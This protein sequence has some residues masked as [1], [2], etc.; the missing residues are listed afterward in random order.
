[1]G[2]RREAL[3]WGCLSVVLAGIVVGRV[4]ADDRFILPA[5]ILAPAHSATVQPATSC[6]I[7]KAH[8]R[9]GPFAWTGSTFLYLGDWAVQST[10]V[11]ATCLVLAAQEKTL[12][13]GQGG[14]PVSRAEI[15]VHVFNT[16]APE[17]CCPGTDGAEK[18]AEWQAV[19]FDSARLGY[20]AGFTP[21]DKRNFIREFGHPGNFQPCWHSR[22]KDQALPPKPRSLPKW[23]ASPRTC[24]EAQACRGYLTAFS[25]GV[26]TQ[27]ILDRD[28]N[29]EM[30]ALPALAGAASLAAALVWMPP[31]RAGRRASRR[32][33]D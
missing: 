20:L 5:L 17:C 3:G 6:W 4:P 25:A 7:P 32:L 22:N 10:F 18:C 11:A 21:T 16:A 28:W 31:R 29:L 9:V 33:Q 19:A 27:V 1:M 23:R 12:P 15:T 30:L 24:R 2:Q 14:V 13:T 26:C 8:L